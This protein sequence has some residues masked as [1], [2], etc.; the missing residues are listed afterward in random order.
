L[1]PGNDIPVCN[2]NIQKRVYNGERHGR[3][4]ATDISLGETLTGTKILA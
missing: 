3:I 1:Q 4:A 2:K